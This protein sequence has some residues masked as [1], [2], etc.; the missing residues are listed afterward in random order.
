MRKQWIDFFYTLSDAVY[1]KA[2][3]ITS[4]FSKAREIQIDM[5]CDPEK[6]RV[7]SNGIDYEAFS[8]I[9][10]EGDGFIN[11]G[12]AVRMAP[13]KDIKTM[14]YA[15]YE[16]SA[17]MPNVRLYVMGGVDLNAYAIV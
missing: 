15:F 7:I 8:T 6:C 5:G 3:C 17:Q 2:D 10:H 11:I 1:S 4:L 14:I 12:A 13:I 16:V 9:P